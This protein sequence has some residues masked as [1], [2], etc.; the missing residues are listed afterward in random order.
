MLSRPPPPLMRPYAS[1]DTPFRAASEMCINA[2]ADVRALG[3]R[4][5]GIR[6]SGVRAH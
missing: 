5:P 1:P 2:A 3:D 4:A 6:A